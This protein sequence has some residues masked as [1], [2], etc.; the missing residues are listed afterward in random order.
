MSQHA[1]NSAPFQ[2]SNL[3]VTTPRKK[4]GLIIGIVC[5]VAAVVAV[6]VIVMVMMARP[7][8][9]DNPEVFVRQYIEHLAAGQAEDARAMERDSVSDDD[10]TFTEA[11]TDAVLSGASERIVLGSIEA[12]DTSE[13]GT[14]LFGVTYLLG[15]QEYEAEIGVS[16]PVGDDTWQITRSLAETVVFPSGLADQLTIGDSSLETVPDNALAVRL[17]PAHYELHAEATYTDFVTFG[18]QDLIVAPDDSDRYAPE[19]VVEWEPELT[20]QFTAAFVDRANAFLHECLEERDNPD[21]E[22]GFIYAVYT[23]GQS[24]SAT[25]NGELT[26]AS[27]ADNQLVSMAHS[28]GIPDMQTDVTSVTLHFRDDGLNI[29]D[30]EQKLAVQGTVE[31]SK[32]SNPVFHMRIVTPED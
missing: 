28:T 18:D 23:D 8:Q 4:A 27:P 22:C 10:G 24:E 9:S 11:R 19:S 5:A 25:L 17:Y 7:S 15:E 13:D 14:H 1:P 26:T 29:P 21:E 2:L 31:L 32:E 3:P 30:K 16:R 20:E 6:A 12:R